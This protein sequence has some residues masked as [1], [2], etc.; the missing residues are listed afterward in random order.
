MIAPVAGAQ[1]DAA[2]EA[3]LAA[4]FDELAEAGFTGFAAIAHDGEIIFAR[5]AGLADPE[6]NRP[7]TLD[8]QV[9]TGSITKS[10]TGM[11]I[12]TLID[13]GRLSPDATLADFF[14]GVPADKAAITVQ[15][16][17]THS[18]GFPGAVGDDL[19]E[20]SWDSF[21][22]N[23]FNADLQFEPGSD[24]AYSNVGFSLLA[25]IIERVTG[26]SY[27]AYLVND[28]LIPAGLTHTGYD[29]VYDDAL[30]ARSRH[31]EA[32]R[33]ASWGGHAPNWNLIGNGGLVSTPREMIA[34]QHAYAGGT[35]VSP[36]AHALAFTPHI[37]EGHGAPSFY[38]YGLV[39]EDDPQIGR[40]YWHNGGNQAFNS[41][42]R[43]LADQ[44][45]ELF[46]TTN[47]RG[48]DTDIAVEALTAAL[49][50]QDYTLRRPASA[51]APVLALDDTLGG[52]VAAEFLAMLA[53]DDENV[54]RDYV[55]NR[56]SDELRAFAPIEGHLDMMRGMHQD[57]GQAEIIAIDESDGRIR[58]SLRDPQSGDVVPVVI[59]Y[60]ED[61][62]VN[63][64]LLG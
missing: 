32:V 58:L 1:T 6:T 12:A 22:T 37:R 19:S 21:A 39:I 60:T 62:L 13:A 44:G 64:L 10:F 40:I 48:I 26:E 20:E 63:G 51:D 52:H 7:F 54:W 27:E 41:H 49:M 56:M 11:A 17:A 53:S 31:G 18:A 42:W 55:L 9:D 16:L 30:A 25:A 59:E 8:T 46:A 4:R 35:L 28:I 15:Q 38:G 2:Q 57:F 43:V 3:R 50:D 47:Q 45:Y 36:G 29:L 23:A 5:G 34:W 14:P 61:G 24:Y 33:Q